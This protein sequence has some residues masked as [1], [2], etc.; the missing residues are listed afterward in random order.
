MSLGGLN[1]ESK[2]FVGGAG[3]GEGAETESRIAESRFLTLFAVVTDGSA[4]FSTEVL[5]R[6][7]KHLQHPKGLEGTLIIEF[8]CSACCASLCIVVLY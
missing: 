2:G 6:I 5:Q 1:K 8:E 4:K 3:R 7:L